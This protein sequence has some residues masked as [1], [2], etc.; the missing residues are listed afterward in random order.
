MERYI[1]FE[2]RIRLLQISLEMVLKSYRVNLNNFK[3][4]VDDNGEDN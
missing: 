2:T 1:F 4:A 3:T